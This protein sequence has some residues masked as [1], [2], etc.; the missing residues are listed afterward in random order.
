MKFQLSLYFRFKMGYEVIFW[1]V[2]SYLGHKDKSILPCSSDF[3]TCSAWFNIQSEGYISQ[4]ALKH[5]RK[6]KLV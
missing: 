4:L 5:N 2:C 3:V 6:I 1:H